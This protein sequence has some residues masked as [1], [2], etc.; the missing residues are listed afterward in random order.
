MSWEDILKINAYDGVRQ[1]IKENQSSFAGEGWD[2]TNMRGQLFSEYKVKGKE[3]RQRYTKELKLYL[4][5]LL[6]ETV[7]FK[8]KHMWKKEELR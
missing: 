5:E 2:F 6:G 7:L 4:N 1:F 8:D 3:N